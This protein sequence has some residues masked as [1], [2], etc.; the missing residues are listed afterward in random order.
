M[1]YGQSLVAPSQL[2]ATADSQSNSDKW[3]KADFFELLS[4]PNE[5]LQFHGGGGDTEPG[6]GRTADG[7]RNIVSW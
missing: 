5:F 6:S 2:A 4:I 7:N 1:T 3:E